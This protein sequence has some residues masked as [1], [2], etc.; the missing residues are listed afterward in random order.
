MQRGKNVILP[1]RGCTLAVGGCTYNLPHKFSPRKIYF[2][3]CGA[4]AATAPPGYAYDVEWGRIRKTLLV[5]QSLTHKL[6]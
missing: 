6:E 5:T 4:P 2:S 1:P 3:P